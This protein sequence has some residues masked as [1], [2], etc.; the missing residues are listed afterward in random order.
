M[1][2]KSGLKA[3]TLSLAIFL[4]VFCFTGCGRA[5]E[6]ESG[7]QSADSVRKLQSLEYASNYQPN[8]DAQ[9]QLIL[10]SINAPTVAWSGRQ[11]LGSSKFEVIPID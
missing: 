7:P 3:M 6:S 4:S 10:P 2:R 1:R 5:G 11:S 9:G 8:I